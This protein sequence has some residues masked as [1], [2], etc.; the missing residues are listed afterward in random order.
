[1]L[2]E[3]IL[4]FLV[5]NGYSQDYKL[6]YNVKRNGYFL[7]GFSHF[8]NEENIKDFV[9][10]CNKIGKLFANDSA[11]FGHCV[12]NQRLTTI[13][14]LNSAEAQKRYT[15][16][17]EQGCCGFYHATWVNPETGNKYKFGFN[18]GH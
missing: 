18:Y 13:G 5:K 3:E 12:D 2:D 17:A 8:F 10:L 14:K 7:L 4:A 6:P 9:W 11:K 1:M 16:A 15:Y